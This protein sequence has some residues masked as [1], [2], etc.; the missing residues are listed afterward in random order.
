MGSVVQRLTWGPVGVLGSR[1]LRSPW[2]GESTKETIT[3]REQGSRTIFLLWNPL[4]L[5][6]DPWKPG[7][8]EAPKPWNWGHCKIKGRAGPCRM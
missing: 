5:F 7:S 3:E 6:M 1:S 4:H 2:L 8:L